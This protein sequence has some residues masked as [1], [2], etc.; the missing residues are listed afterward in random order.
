MKKIVLTGACGALGMQI[1]GT[2]ADLCDELL[3]VDIAPEPDSLLPNERFAQV[4][5][6]DLDAFL[7]VAEGAWMIVHFAS[8]ADERPFEELLRPNFLSSYA[9]WE[10]AYR[11]GAQRVIYASSVHGVGMH[12]ASAGIGL[13]ADHRPDTFYGLA[14]CFAEDLGKLYWD[15]RGVESVHLR[16][17]SCTAEPQNVRALQTWLSHDDLRQL[18]RRAVEARTTGF[19]CIYGISANTRAPVNNDKA[20]FLGYRPT[21]NAEDWAETLMANAPA[22]DPKDRAQMCLGGP[23]ATVP[24]GESGV[25]GIKA[26]AAAAATD[27]PDDTP[28]PA[29]EATPDPVE[30]AK[31]TTTGKLPG[32]LSKRGMD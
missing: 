21:D 1:R 29:P 13:D 12:E 19:C 2:L 22:A 14:K 4:D 28:A 11:Q 8:I 32:F 17:F 5:V 24:L 10:A 31:P 23:F 15:K 7:P 6:A 18:V 26:M 25:A 16:I 9:V 20:A 30:P 3:S 27:A